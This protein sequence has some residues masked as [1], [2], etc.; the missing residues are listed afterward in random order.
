[1]NEIDRIAKAGAGNGSADGLTPVSADALRREIAYHLTYSIGKDPRAASLSDW[2]LAL[3]RAIRDRV[4][5]PW[6]A[7][8]RRTYE[9]D[10][11]RV[12]YLSME[13]LIGRLLEDAVTN[14]G[15]EDAAREAMAA[16][17]QDYDAAVKDEPDAALG[18]GGLGRLAACFLDS[19]STVG[20]PAHGYGI[21]YDHG[22]FKQSFRDGW[23]HEEPEDWLN[24]VHPWEFERRETLYPVGFGGRVEAGETGARWYAN[25]TVLA[26]AYDTPTPGWG[27]R[28]V[29]T[30]RLWSAKPTR[31]F[32]L[33]PF[34]RGDFMGAA[35]PAVLAETISRVLYPDDTTPQGKE[36][37]LKQEYFF[38]AASLADILRRF[39][40]HHDDAGKLPGLVA[41]QLNDTHPAIAG[42]ELVRLLIDERGLGFDEAFA[43]A[44]ATLNYTNHTLMP[45]ALERW[46]VDMMA[47]VLPRHLQLIEAMDAAHAAETRA[48]GH[49]RP[50]SAAALAHGEVRM[51]NLAFIA[52]NRVNGVSALHT[53]LMKRTVFADLHALHPDKILNQT[54]GVTPRR[55]IRGCNPAMA[56]L[57]TEALGPEWETDLNRLQGLAPL[58]DDAA[59]RA[60][61]MAA[62][63]QNKAALAQWVEA[64]MGLTIDPAAMF[65]IQIKRMHE[66]KRQFMNILELAALYNEIKRDPSAVH[67][68]RVRFFS[69]KAAPGYWM[70]KLIVK[71]IND[72]GAT[73]NADPA[74]AGRLTVVYPPNYNV[75]QAERLIPAADLSEQISTAG[76]EASG[77]G[78]MK[79]AMNGALTIGTNDGANVEIRER[80]GDENIFI[81]GLEADEVTALRAEGFDPAAHVAASDRLSEVVDQIRAGFYSGGD[82][83]RFA[84]LTDNL[85]GHDW[86]MV[87]A[88]FEAYWAAQRRVDAAWAD[89]E[90]WARKAVL[91]AAPMGWF[92]S[93]R[94]IHGYAA[95]VWEVATVL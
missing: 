66:Y 94:T 60:R 26:A 44:R 41:I 75:T 90:G 9:E 52:A 67:P 16:L 12:Y 1:M 2:R 37:R 53:D 80:V 65:D 89:P 64:Q 48:R 13:F 45:E 6:F 56:A 8:T 29:N 3:S 83:E 28:W 71:L 92:S 35:A 4:V 43:I 70:A 69:G 18:N 78:N 55:W 42:P 21:R 95:D 47:R 14:L 49:Q 58:A 63:H 77:T 38:T 11:K 5:E 93:D 32:D 22:L 24:E 82:G 59:F 30:L 54:N 25:E 17:G 68:P 40:A 74:M 7:T 76:T 61:F 81:F 84:A 51:G 36:L 46:P 31:V 34:N 73:V 19:M 20:V 15:L 79:F 85:T 62:K 50:D 87:A 39:F 57:L 88:D 33:E 10:R 86:F 91:N 27:G 72:I 23:Q